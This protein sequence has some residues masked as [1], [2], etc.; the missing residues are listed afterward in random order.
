MGVATQHEKLVTDCP[1]SG[2][3]ANAS[4]D[5]NLALAQGYGR[6][7]KCGARIDTG[8]RELRVAGNTMAAPSTMRKR[9]GKRQKK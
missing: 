8:S 2:E 6:C 5:R 3:L 4:A 7:I 1:R 9:F